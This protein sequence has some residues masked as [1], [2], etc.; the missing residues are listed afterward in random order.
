MPKQMLI[1]VAVLAG[2]VAWYWASRPNSV[3]HDPLPTL[4]VLASLVVMGLLEIAPYF[5]KQPKPEPVPVRPSL[6]T[7]SGPEILVTAME[8]ARMLELANIE[9]DRFAELQ[10]ALGRQMEHQYARAGADW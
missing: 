8:I 3:G 5:R 1:R 6:R 2:F 4:L 10:T 9:L 7:D